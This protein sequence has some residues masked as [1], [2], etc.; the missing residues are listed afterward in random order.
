MN[1]VT[2]SGNVTRDPEL[3]FT[4]NGKA[5]AQFGVAVSKKTGDKEYTSFF[6]VKC[7]GAIAEGAAQN[8]RK[9]SPV[10]VSGELQQE[11]WDDKQTGQ[12]RSKV[13]ITAF[14]VGRIAFKDQG[15]QQPTQQ[16]RQAAPP[17]T[18]AAPSDNDAGGYGD[19]GGDVPY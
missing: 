16:R 17:T 10:I 1:T 18:A 6:D 3:R 13:V 19:D 14:T 9:G 12:K 7:W 11:S 2:I 5:V 8:L 4:P 15:Q